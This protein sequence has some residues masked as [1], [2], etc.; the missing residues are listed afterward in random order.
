MNSHSRNSHGE[1]RHNSRG[2][3]RPQIFGA[4][5]LHYRQGGA[6]GNTET[7]P[8]WSPE[9]AHDSVYPYTLSEYTRD[10]RRWMSLTKVAI[11]RQRVLALTIGQ[12]ALGLVAPPPNAARCQS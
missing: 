4:Q 1:S 5:A 12:A 8:T 3:A 7:P 9:M 6:M 2:E 11:E 10:I